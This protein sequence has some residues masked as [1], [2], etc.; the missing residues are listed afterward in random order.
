VFI[1][2]IT[3]LSTTVLIQLNDSDLLKIRDI[4]NPIFIVL[5]PH[6]CLGQ[7]F[8]QLA[9]LYNTK[10]VKNAYG[11]AFSYDPFSLDN[12]GG[13]LLALF[14]QGIFF[15]ILNLLIQ[16][17]FFVRFKPK[18]ILSKNELSS[19]N[20][21]S[22][23]DDVA[24]EQIRIQNVMNQFKTK[25]KK[26]FENKK[27]IELK[28]GNREKETAEDNDQRDYVKLVNLSKT[29]KKFQLKKFRHKKHLAVNN[30][31]LGINKDECFGLIGVNGAGKTTTFKMITGEM[32]ITAGDVYVGEHCVSKE[33]EK[34]HKNIGYW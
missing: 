32:N 6:Y 19:S 14:L 17:K 18:K 16:Y 12:I 30:L 22:L 31:S 33:I 3:T 9:I 28:E 2:T 21:V 5:F 15:N 11:I 24:A 1:G 29:F 23:D 13:N 27:D 34:V 4:L 10:K 26:R 8:I 7:G 25:K 20:D